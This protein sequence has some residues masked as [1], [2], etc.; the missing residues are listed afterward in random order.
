M[1]GLEQICFEMI[2]YNGSA[3]SAFVEAMQ[4]AEK[5]QFAKAEE[6][7]AGGDADLA[8]GHQVHAKLLQQEAAGQA[9]EINLLLLH[10]EDLMMAAETLKIV[11]TQVIELHKRLAKK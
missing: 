1:E 4:A 3:R 5:G 7:M 11:A 6:L 10:A 2:S 9:T 8:H